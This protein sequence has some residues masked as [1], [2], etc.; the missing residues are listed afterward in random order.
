[1]LGQDRLH[2]TERHEVLPNRTLKALQL[3]IDRHAEL[4][5]PRIAVRILLR[6]L[7]EHLSLHAEGVTRL[8]EQQTVH[9]LTVHARPEEQTLA[10]LLQIR[11]KS[12]ED[13]LGFARIVDGELT[14]DRIKLLET[15][16]LLQVGC[17]SRFRAIENADVRIVLLVQRLSH[18]CGDEEHGGQLGRL[19]AFLEVASTGTLT[20]G[21]EVSRGEIH[22]HDLGGL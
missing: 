3:D 21:T 11:R 9:L 4:I 2:T 10:M 16:K 18:I 20:R 13:L 22:T 19:L 6:D 5:L 1:M 8:S 14:R 15:H 12:M 7:S 17:R